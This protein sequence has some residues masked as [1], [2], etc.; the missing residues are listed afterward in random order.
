MA[1]LWVTRDGGALVMLTADVPAGLTVI[2]ALEQEVEVETRFGG[3]FV[4][5]IDGLEGSLLSQ[6]DWFYFV[7]GIEPDVGAAE[8]I[9]GDGDIAWWDYRSWG[10]EMRQPVVVGAF[11]EPFRR[12]FGSPRPVEV[13]APPELAEEAA[14]LRKF[15]ESDAEPREPHRFVLLVEEGVRGARLSGTRGDASDS[16]VTFTL[17]GSLEEVRV[18][19]TTLV[20]DPALVRFCYAAQ[21]DPDGGVVCLGE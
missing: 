19:A 5:A 8:V 16:P 4:H 1:E 14:A 10:E 11:P 7:N 20:D 17:A 15:L 3:R 18:G 6:E 9:L 12:G 21:F 13:V 2:Q